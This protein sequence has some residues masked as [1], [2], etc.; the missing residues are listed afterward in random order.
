MTN[1]IN[2][3]LVLSGGG[4]RGLAHAGM[5]HALDQMK[6][7]PGILAG[8]SAGA[9]ISVM[10]AGG[11]EPSDMPGIMVSSRLFEIGGISFNL[12]GLLKTD[13]FRKI[14]KENVYADTFEELSVPVIVNVTDFTNGKQLTFES[15]PFTDVVVASCSIPLIFTPVHLNGANLVDGGLTDN[16]PVELIRSR[17]RHLI[18]MNVN[19]IGVQKRRN[20]SGT[21]ERIFQMAISTGIQQKATQCDLFLEPSQLSDYSVFDTKKAD[22]IFRIGFDETMKHRHA[23]EK[24]AGLK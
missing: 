15:G 14:L 13:V 8:S 17:C 9:I 10:Y 7:K 24:M 19:P 16:F 1:K 3:G 18:G 5:L 20:L 6:V 21:L 22:E 4:A 12:K 23:I 11:V 2:L